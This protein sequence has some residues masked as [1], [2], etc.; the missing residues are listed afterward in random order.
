MEIAQT[1]DT[2]SKPANRRMEWNDLN[3]ENTSE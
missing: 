2:N 1:Y 3:E